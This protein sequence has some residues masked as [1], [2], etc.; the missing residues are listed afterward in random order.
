[1]YPWA[2]RVL[3]VGLPRVWLVVALVAVALQAKARVPLQTLRSLAPY[4]YWEA[5][6]RFPA[7]FPSRSACKASRF[8]TAHP[9]RFLS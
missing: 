1:M 2:S 7:L 8:P 4:M 5:M 9:H 3:D 6:L